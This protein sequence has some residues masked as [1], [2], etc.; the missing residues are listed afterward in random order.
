[1]EKDN[2]AKANKTSRNYREPIFVSAC[3]QMCSRVE[4]SYSSSALVT[5]AVAFNAVSSANMITYSEVHDQRRILNS[6]VAQQ[7]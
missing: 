5:A 4:V 2:S 7:K 3:V 6:H 1:M